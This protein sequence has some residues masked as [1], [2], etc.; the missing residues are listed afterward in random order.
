MLP[1]LSQSVGLFLEVQGSSAWPGPAGTYTEE[2]ILEFSQ[3]RA[4]SVVDY[5]VS[6]GIDPARF[7]V[8]ATLPPES[9]R[10]TEDPNIQAEDRYV[11]MTLITV[12]R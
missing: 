8:N 7:V 9:H 11:E 3:A 5:L 2:Q 1:T 6:K 4:Q 12:G 10:E